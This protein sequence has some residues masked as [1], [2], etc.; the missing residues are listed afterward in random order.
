L[1]ALATHALRECLANEACQPST[2]ALFL[3]VREPHRVNALRDWSNQ[4]LLKAIQK[5]LGMEFHPLSQVLPD[6][7]AAVF[8]GIL[9]ARTLLSTNQVDRC[10]VGGVDSFLNQADLTR[11]QS[12]YRLK[13]EDVAQGLIPGEAAGFVVVANNTTAPSGRV[14]GEILGVGTAQEDPA[15][16]V[17]N[18]GHP[19]GKGL[20]RAL[21]ATV[22]DAAVPE[23]RIDFRVSDLNGESYR[24]MESM[25][26]MGRFYRTRRQGLPNW[27]PAACVGETGAAVGAVLIIQAVVG[28][29]RGYAPGTMAMGE[30]ASD[31]GLRAGCLIGA[32]GAWPSEARQ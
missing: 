29:A 4:G 19:T 18:D 24:G 32:P 21:E 22:A 9:R 3:G 6:G 2:T 31:G 1:V 20:Q 5:D 14:R 28:M 13:S 10:I 27:Y 7:N 30:A 8:H 11:L 23:G 26:A 12:W 16:T 25:L 15:V 17:L